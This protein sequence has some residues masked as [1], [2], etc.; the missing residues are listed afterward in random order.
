MSD[1]SL[2]LCPTSHHHQVSFHLNTLHLSRKTTLQELT[3]LKTNSLKSELSCHQAMMLC[4]HNNRSAL[5]ELRQPFMQSSDNHT[6]LA[7]GHSSTTC[8][9]SRAYLSVG[10]VAS[11]ATRLMYVPTG[12]RHNH[13]S[14]TCASQISQRAGHTT[15]TCRQHGILCSTRHLHLLSNHPGISIQHTYLQALSPLDISHRL[16]PA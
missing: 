5:R 13:P 6:C 16:T 1:D 7:E 14:N 3:R 2:I 9:N 11:S 4:I 12:S 10:P 15:P 8:A